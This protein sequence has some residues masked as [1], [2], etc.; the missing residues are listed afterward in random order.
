MSPLVAAAQLGALAATAVLGAALLVFAHRLLRSLRPAAV[1]LDLAPAAAPTVLEVNPNSIA[2]PGFATAAPVAADGDELEQA[3]AAPA[4]RRRQPR[5]LDVAATVVIGVLLVVSVLRL[6]GSQADAFATGDGQ[7]MRASFV[8]GC[9]RD[10]D[11]RYDC[12]CVFDRLTSSAPY[13]TTQGFAVLQAAIE[14]ASASGTATG[15]PVVYVTAVNGC[16][17]A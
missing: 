16:R 12:G 14:K 11:G 9:E 2:P 15:W 4:P 5:A 7:S 10:A 3:L 1:V 13:D 6:G 8:A 17:A